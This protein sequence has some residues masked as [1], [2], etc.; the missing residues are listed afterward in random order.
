[1]IINLLIK[2]INL[3]KNNLYKI[4]IF[5]FLVL[6][7]ES[8]IFNSEFLPYKINKFKQY[9]ID[10]FEGFPNNFDIVNGKFISQN[11]D[12]NITIKPLDLSIGYIYVNCRNTI[13]DSQ[14]QIYL[15]EKGSIFSEE[16]SIIFSLN[17]PKKLFKLSDIQEISSIRLD[18]TNRAGDIVSC[19]QIIINPEV[20]FNFFRFFLTYFILLCFLLGYQ[21]LDTDK[22]VKVKDFLKKNSLINFAIVISI[23]DLLYPITIT[24][25]S[26]HYL[27][28]AD[29]IN[30][31][32][33]VNWDPIRYI[34]FPLNLYLSQNL[35]GYNQNALLFPL[36]VSHLILFITTYSIISN[37]FPSLSKKFGHYIQLFVMLFIVLDTTVIGYYHTL[38]TE[39]FAATIAIFSC[40][41]SLKIY[42]TNVFSK[43]FFMWSSFFLFLVPF[44]WHLKQPYI[45]TAYFPLLIVS[46]LIVS[47]SFSKKMILYVITINI[48]SLFLVF[49]TTFAWNSFLIAQK[50]PMESD[51]LISTRLENRIDSKIST[52]QKTPIWY[53]KD[54]F[55]RYLASTNLFPYDHVNRSLIYNPCLT[56]SF[57]NKLVAHRMFLNLELTNIIPSNPHNP[58]T[59]FL[60][61]SYSPPNWINNIFK[62]S[63]K[64][65]NFLYTSTY[66]ILPIF[67]VV[68]FFLWFRYKNNFITILIILSGSSL[69]NSIAHIFLLNSVLD[70]YRF[71]GYPLNL[72]C[73]II[74][75]IFV[76][77]RFRMRFIEPKIS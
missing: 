66:L 58:Y 76:V 17:S 26:G 54:F 37:L 62:S 20:K 43:Q 2:T 25:D 69:L 40:Y 56:C 29:V 27:W 11:D 52:V 67:V 53:G 48:I 57:Q 14:A 31:G 15:Q 63:T 3:I 42:K 10:V 38:L 12:P 49:L 7:L 60:E 68:L 35:F 1:M 59:S 45:G 77:N 33:W 19:D 47:K 74:L 72:L 30:Q 61:T 44:S 23:I 39:Y 6:F 8:I 24:W 46:L 16:N 22:K 75:I 4:L 34:I 18:L 73:L 21:S 51:R 9:E 50:N 65:S 70:R 55:K 41:V 13:S 32:E 64:F 5:F 71:W 28:L 36:I